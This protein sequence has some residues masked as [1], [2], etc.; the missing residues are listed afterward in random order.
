MVG[1]KDGPELGQLLGRILERRE[2]DRPLIERQ[3][4][5]LH[6]GVEGAVEPVGQ[7]LRAGVTKE[8]RE[9]LDGPVGNG[10]PG[11]HH[12]PTLAWQLLGNS[13]SVTTL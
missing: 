13:S 5:Q 8:A 3:R 12:P 10:Q 6:L 11:E 4:D 9:L 1:Q 2:H 7:L